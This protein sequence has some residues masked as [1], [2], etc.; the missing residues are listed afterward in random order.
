MFETFRLVL[1]KGFPQEGKLIWKKV[2]LFCHVNSV[3][4]WLAWFDCVDNFLSPHRTRVRSRQSFDWKV[5]LYPAIR[6]VVYLSFEQR[7]L[8]HGLYNRIC[9]LIYNLTLL[10]GA[11]FT[12]PKILICTGESV[13]MKSI[14][15]R[16]ALCSR[17]DYV[18]LILDG[19]VRFTLGQNLRIL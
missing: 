4:T 5:D 13:K 7:Q 3:A 1:T 9:L 2:S 16:L 15:N 12:W 11:N 6:G 8:N 19:S 14:V 17:R 10:I 18:K